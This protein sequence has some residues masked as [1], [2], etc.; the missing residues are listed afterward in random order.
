MRSALAQ[1][2][3]G[4]SLRRTTHL[5]AISVI[6]WIL[7]IWRGWPGTRRPGSGT[8]SGDQGLVGPAHKRLKIVLAVQHQAAGRDLP[9]PIA[10][11]LPAG[12][13]GV[14]AQYL[15]PHSQPLAD[16]ALIGAGPHVHVGEGRAA[17]RPRGGHAA[18]EPDE[19]VDGEERGWPEECEPEAL[20]RCRVQIAGNPLNRR[21]VPERVGPGNRPIGVRADVIRLAGAA[22]VRGRAVIALDR[23]LR[24]DL[25]V[26]VH[27][28][29][30]ADA[31]FVLPQIGVQLVRARAD[32]GGYLRERGGTSVRVDEY[33]LVPPLDRDR[34]E[35]DGRA[36]EARLAGL[37]GSVLEPAV[38]LVRPAVVGAPQQSRV[39][40]RRCHGVQ[41]VPAD[42]DK[43]P[44]LTVL[45]AD[46]HDGD[47]T[48]FRQDDVS[49]PCQLRVMAGVLPRPRK[50]LL[51]FELIDLRYRI[52]QR[53]KGV[54]GG[55]SGENICVRGEAVP[56]LDITQSQQ[57]R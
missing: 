45:S 57:L 52:E 55:K 19:V 16:D 4:I 20:Q 54:T 46:D 17:L 8:G 14:F 31:I 24:P 43:A 12:G 3:R 47:V 22:T 23:V 48:R 29:G 40:V 44:K 56:F 9:G 53:R 49:W 33:E 21:F 26:A 25:P 15:V 28:I 27:L 35:R 2:S 34:L 37:P 50:D 36:V 41:A 13:H 18:D 38:K 32:S 5:G 39:L 51:L 1:L 11:L 10:H 7:L 6:T 30:V 42:V